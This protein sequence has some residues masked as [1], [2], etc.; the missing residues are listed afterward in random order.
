MMLAIFHELFAATLYALHNAIPHVTR[1][2]HV[3]ST[4][5]SQIGVTQNSIFV[6]DNLLTI[7]ATFAFYIG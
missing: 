4:T 5:L 6:N 1:S 7:N 3:R 2:A